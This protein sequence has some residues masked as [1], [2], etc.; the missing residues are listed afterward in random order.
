M[1]PANSLID[2]AISRGMQ[3]V[4]QALWT[5]AQKM[6]PRMDENKQATIW[7]SVKGNPQALQSY[8]THLGQ[9]QGITDPT[10]LDKLAGEYIGAQYA[11]FGD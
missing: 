2:E 11:K 10:E 1:Q 8:I 3:W 9:R 4:D 6:L 7:H 5:S